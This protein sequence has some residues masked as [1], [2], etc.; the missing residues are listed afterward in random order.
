MHSTGDLTLERVL[1]HR[2]AVDPGRTFIVW[3]AADGR[4]TEACYGEIDALVD[5]LA[6]GLSG[7]GVGRG[8]PVIVHSA[9]RPE[10]VVAL[11]ALAR[12]GAIGVPTI[13]QYTADEL[14]YVVGHVGAVGIVCDAPRLAIAQEASE[15]HGVRFLLSMAPDAPAPWLSWEEGLADAAGGPPIEP[16]V[17][18]E[19]TGIVMYSSGTTARPKGIELSHRALMVAAEINAQHQRLRPE[20]RWMCIVPVF[21]VNGLLISTMATMVTGS[22]IVLTEQ[23]D[24]ARY[25]RQLRTYQATVAFV[26]AMVARRLLGEPDRPSDREHRLRLMLYGMPLAQEEVEA[27]E[28]R[29]DVP[30][31]NLWGMTENAG[32]GTRT[33]PYLPRRA[34]AIGLPVLGSEVRVVDA[35]GIEVPRGT[36]GRAHYRGAGLAAGYLR[37]PDTTAATFDGGWLDTRDVMAADELGYLSFLDRDKDMIKVKAEN[38]SSSE[39]ERAIGDHPAVAEVAAVGVPDD[40]LGERVVAFVV[41]QAGR[42]VDADELRRHA[43]RSLAR[44]KVPSDIHLVDALPKTSTEKVK[45]AALRRRAQELA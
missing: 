26:P 16:G 32:L 27:F 15:P 24:F 42:S 7:L 29:F 37:D 1:R 44:F 9:N 33:P 22:S 28:R 14:G 4:W 5:R 6:G 13:A 35:D 31:V 40:R 45:K 10:S 36:P 41:V 17:S 21:H 8:D 11:L 12:L 23:F 19:D 20:D 25:L 2:A 43:G 34:A 38:V 30:L 3:E 39:V 18:V